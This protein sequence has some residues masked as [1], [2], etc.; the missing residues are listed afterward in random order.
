MRVK[1]I[2]AVMLLIW[3]V[4]LSRVYYLAVVSNRYYE[5]IALGNVIKTELIAPTRGQ[6]LD[7]N[8]RPMAINK[9]GFAILLAPHLKEDELKEEARVLNSV[10]PQISSQEIQKEYQKQNSPYNHEFIEVINF[11]E[12]EE[13][14]PYFSKLNL[15]ENLKLIS[16]SKRYYPY[17][18][19]ASHVIGYVGRVNIKDIEKDPSV[20]IVDFIG[21]SGVERYHNKILQGEPGERKIKVT[22]LNRAVE[23][24][25][26]KKSK[27]SSISLHIDIE[28]QE[29]LTELFKD[30]A[31]VAIIMDVNTGA[32]IAA[33]SFPEYD[34]N[35]FVSGMSWS[36][37]KKLI[38]D[39]DHPFTNKLVNGLYPPA[40]T[41]KMAVGMAF[42]NS[43]LI[44]EDTIFTCKGHIK[45]GGRNFRC[46]KTWGHGD[47]NLKDAIRESCDVYFYEGGLIVGIDF[48]AQTLRN[49]GFGNKTGVDLPNEFIGTIPDKEWKM[50]R[51]RQPWFTGETVISS[52]GQGNMLITPMQMVKHTAEIASGK[53]LVPHF[54]KSIDEKD[55]IYEERE[56]FSDSEKKLLPS[57]RKAM[58]EVA[59]HPKGTAYRTLSDCAVKIAAKTGTAQVI[60]IPQNEKERMKEE[61]MKYYERSHSWLTTYG[62]YD[63]PKYAVTVLIEHG[64]GASAASP[65]IKA[66]YKKL[67][68]LGYIKQEKTK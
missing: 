24:L 21:R 8:N 14:V 9:L 59:N 18:Q 12:Y 25:Y 45:L 46:W 37:W 52:I 5:E 51:F 40:S 31:G 68:E 19:L 60:S 56:L 61:D 16:S 57:I 35:P 50:A 20:R 3:V 15:R 54:I 65:Y 2:I 34:L 27:S 32:I 33:G 23:E 53:G 58:Y 17:G 43:G 62:P 63:N 42:I 64:G 38:E 39:F 1:F 13:V 10:F 49:Y 47:R 67:L 44:R 22:A 36:E 4:L 6:I 30:S 29:F 41:I 48:I 55:V 7:R 26:Y 11:L 66:I 28:L